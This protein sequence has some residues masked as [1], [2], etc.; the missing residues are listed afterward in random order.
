MENTHRIREVLE[1]NLHIFVDCIESLQKVR[2]ACFGFTLD[3]NYEE[4]IE[5]F[6][7]DWTQLNH[8][9][10]IS[11]PN[12]VHIITSHLADFIELQ[13]KPLGSSQK[14]WLRQL[15]K[16]LTRFGSGMLRKWWRK[17]VMV[18]NSSTVLII[19]TL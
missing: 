1:D 14:K 17:K 15:I 9:F 7:A 19:L 8:E 6:K 11:F 18:K 5:D 3:G 13:K 16:D 2:K 12:K 10:G 4:Y